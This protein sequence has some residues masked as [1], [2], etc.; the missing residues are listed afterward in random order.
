MVYDFMSGSRLLFSMLLILLEG[1]INS[2]HANFCQSPHGYYNLF[3]EKWYI[4]YGISKLIKHVIYYHVGGA[5]G[6]S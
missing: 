4:V 5:L 3:I 2:M 6:Q 1:G